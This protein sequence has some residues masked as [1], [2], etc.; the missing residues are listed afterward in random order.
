MEKSLNTSALPSAS[1]EFMFLEQRIITIYFNSS[2]HKQATKELD[3]AAFLR[4]CAQ[5]IKISHAAT[6]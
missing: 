6:S 2:H 3:P 1:N 4:N 5:A